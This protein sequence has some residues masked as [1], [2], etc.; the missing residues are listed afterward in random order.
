MGWR[1]I[2]G[3]LLITSLFITTQAQAAIPTAERAALLALYTTTNGDNWLNNTG[4]NG[5]AGTECNW[6]GVSCDVDQT[7]ITGLIL[8]ANNLKGPMPAE[9]ANLTS[10]TQTDFR[11]NA[12]YSDNTTLINFIDATGPIGSLHDTQTLDATGLRFSDFT[13]TGF[14]LNWDAVSYTAAGGYRVLMA[15]QIDTDAGSSMTNFVQIADTNS[16]D[17][18]SSTL[19]ELVP[20]RQYFFKVLSYTSINDNNSVEVVS[21]GV[22]GPIVGTISGFNDTCAIIG[23]PY[24]DS[25]VIGI[26]TPENIPVL[27]EMDDSGS[28]TYTLSGNYNGQ[29]YGGLGNDNFSINVSSS[30]SIYGGDGDD[31]FTI[32]ASVSGI[33]SGGEGSDTYNI[34]FDGSASE[35]I[36]VGSGSDALVAGD[37]NSNLVITSESSGS[38]ND[39]IYFSGFSVLS[40]GSGFDSYTIDGSGSG[41]IS[42]SSIINGGEISFADAG[43]LSLNSGDVVIVNLV[44]FVGGVG[45]VEQDEDADVGTVVTTLDPHGF[46]TESLSYE[47]KLGNEDGQFTINQ[48]TGE[49]SIAKSLDYETNTSHTLIIT[50]ADNE[51]AMDVEV[52][53]NVNDVDEES[54]GCSLRPGAPFDPVLVL[55][56]VMALAYRFRQAS[57]GR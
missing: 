9:L 32:Y 51:S 6:F 42:G 56:M 25:Y 53:V 4:W 38:L 18:L 16:K 37:T 27:I 45:V 41:Q 28:R 23:S 30:A 35:I 20:C 5:A 49:I 21:D 1:T 3:L 22:G 12:I 26:E 44:K 36:D 39:S 50:V 57:V 29:I 19:T 52:T 40:G 10:L 33:L 46:D 47:F 43:G 8:S 2:P 11:Y 54:G 15:E 31:T 13:D 14:D 17:V 34:L 48:A 7:A 55:M 24:D